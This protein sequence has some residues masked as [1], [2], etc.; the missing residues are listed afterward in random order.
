MGWPAPETG[1]NCI[2][3]SPIYMVEPGA[4]LFSITSIA[5]EWRNV[6]NAVLQGSFSQGLRYRHQLVQ[7]LQDLR[8]HPVRRQTESSK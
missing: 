8:D 7:I 4:I 5:Y 2:D 1:R 6:Q 3:M